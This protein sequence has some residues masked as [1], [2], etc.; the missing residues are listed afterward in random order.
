MVAQH[1]ND[2][3]HKCAHFGNLRVIPSKT[4]VHPHL[5]RNLRTLPWQPS[6]HAAKNAT[7][8]PLCPPPS[9]VKSR[10]QLLIADKTMAIPTPQTTPASIA[11][12]SPRPNSATTPSSAAVPKSPPPHQ[13]PAPKSSTSPSAHAPS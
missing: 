8:P 9:C 5:P 7:F 12:P 10:H 1:E 11:A 3:P 4:R 2:A 13:T 6:A